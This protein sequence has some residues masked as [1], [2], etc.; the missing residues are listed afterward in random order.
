M[1]VLVPNNSSN[2][3]SYAQRWIVWVGFLRLSLAPNNSLKLG[4]IESWCAYFGFEI[5][6]LFIFHLTFF[7]L[8][9]TTIILGFYFV[10]S[11]NSPST[12]TLM[13]LSI[14]LII[15]G[16]ANWKYV[17]FYDYLDHLTFQKFL[18]CPLHINFLQKFH[19]D[20]EHIYQT[21]HT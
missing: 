6:H 21:F 13:L 8:Y 14:K 16:L 1:Y 3:S 12:S 18:C 11:N 7:K 4:V 2:S 5:S 10:L 9:W 17:S 19:V 15:Y 20:C